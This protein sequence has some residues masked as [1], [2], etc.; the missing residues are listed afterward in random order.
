MNTLIREPNFTDPD[1]FY[2]ALTAANEG[3]SEAQSAAF[4]R[5]LALI[6]ANHIGADQVLSEAIALARDVAQ[7]TP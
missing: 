1:V 7:D 4:S 2:A 5:A 3:L 6:L